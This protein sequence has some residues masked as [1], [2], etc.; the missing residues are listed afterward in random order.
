MFKLSRTFKPIGLFCLFL[1]LAAAAEASPITINS[2]TASLI[3]SFAWDWGVNLIGN[4]FSVSTSQAGLDLDG[5]TKSLA[6]NLTVFGDV[7]GGEMGINNHWYPNVNY[8]GFVRLEFV[9][10]PITLL[11]GPILQGVS[12]STPFT[13]TGVVYFPGVVSADLVGNGNLTVKWDTVNRGYYSAVFTFVPE[14]SSFAFLA[15]GFASVAVLAWKRKG[16]LPVPAE[17]RGNN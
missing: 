16:R 3:N 4:G 1:S 11:Q 10:D 8:A 13:M 2:G 9:H 15:I 12:E 5:F 6:S 7:R 14:P 17:R